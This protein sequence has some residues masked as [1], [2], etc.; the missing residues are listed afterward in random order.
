MINAYKLARPYAQAVFEYALEHNAVEHWSAMVSM[1][2]EWVKQPILRGVL[3]SPQLTREQLIDIFLQ[4]GK[5]GLDEKTVNLIKLLAKKRRLILLPVIQELFEQFRAHS[6][7][8]IEVNVSSVIPLDDTYKQTLTQVL[9]K[10]FGRRVALNCD[11]DASLIGGLL[12]R[13]G[14]KVID[15]SVRGRLERMREA[16]V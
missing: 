14:D 7:Q 1:L 13:T 11:I 9:T 16:L 5:N 12:I 2:A 6:E 4:L 3:T 15:N 10:K 8:I